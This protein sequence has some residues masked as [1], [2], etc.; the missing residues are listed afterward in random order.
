MNRVKNLYAA[1][2]R[3]APFS[4]QLE[5]DNSDLIVGDM[6]AVVSKVYVCL[7]A[8]CF[9]VAKAKEL[10]CEL[11]ISHHPAIFRA[12]KN[13]YVNSIPYQLIANGISLISA[14][15]NLDIADKGVNYCLAEALGLKNAYAPE[16]TEIGFIG[17]LEEV[18]SAEKFALLVKEKLGAGVCMN[19]FGGIIKKVGVV[20]GA[21]GEYAGEFFALGA[22]AFVT[23]EVKHHEYLEANNIG[24]TIIA[25]GH[26]ETEQVVVKPLRDMLAKEFEEI[27]F[28]AADFKRPTEYY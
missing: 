1:I 12:V 9:A 15:T 23:G 21:G 14:H 18:L 4:S 11:I 2:N 20:G 28:Y 26:Y 5:W 7:D 22:D 10:G 24:K 16:E 25:A 3:I 19:N 27:E 8:D 13:V 6:N 17:E